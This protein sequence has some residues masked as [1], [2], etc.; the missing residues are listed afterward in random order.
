MLHSLQAQHYKFLTDKTPMSPVF[1]VI[2]H[3]VLLVLPMMAALIYYLFTYIY[4]V[5]VNNQAVDRQLPD[6]LQKY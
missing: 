6:S 5:I 1:H 3:V 4:G 2:F